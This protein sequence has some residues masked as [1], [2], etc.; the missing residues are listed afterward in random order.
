M[1]PRTI[2]HLVVFA[3]FLGP[4]SVPAQNTPTI[5]SYQDIHHPIFAEQGM[6]STQEELAS[7]VGLEVLQNGGN[8]IDA[9]VAIGFTLAV[10]LPRAGNLG[11]GGFMLIHSASRGETVAIDYRE[12]A[13]AAAT[14]DMYLDELGNVDKDK[15]RYSYHSVGVPGTVAGLA[16]ALREYGTWSLPR[17]LEPAIRHAREGIV[18][19]RDL[20][21]SLAYSEKR[22]RKWPATAQIFLKPDGSAYQPGDRLIQNDLAWSLEQIA[23][24]GPAAFYQG[25]T[26][27]AKRIVTDM[28]S[29]DGLIDAQ[30][31]E[32]YQAHI[33]SPVHG[34]YRGYQ[35]FSMPPPSSGGVH[36]SP[37]SQYSRGLSD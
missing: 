8:A 27:V 5:V 23:Q 29:G 17:V 26:G 22:L 11:G 10:T 21:D 14:R 28:E 25:E 4:V 34:T 31:L 1:S 19:R 2:Y 7:R 30:D 20:A 32:S 6:V 36:L 15:S 3:T 13:P 35:I 16:L 24:S 18:V 33:R 12:T 37:D 9:G